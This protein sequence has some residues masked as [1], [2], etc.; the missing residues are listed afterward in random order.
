MK[1]H[2]YLLFNLENHDDM[3]QEETDSQEYNVDLL[4][5]DEDEVTE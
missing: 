4:T 1:F 2:F 5:A 3:S